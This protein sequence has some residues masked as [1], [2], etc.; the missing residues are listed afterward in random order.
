MAI[1][2]VL[3][4]QSIAVLFALSAMCLPPGVSMAGSNHALVQ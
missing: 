2:G 3:A 4:Q 1:L